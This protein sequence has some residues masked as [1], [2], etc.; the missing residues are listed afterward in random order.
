MGSLT[1]LSAADGTQVSA[2][3]AQPGQDRLDFV[4]RALAV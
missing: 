4:E 2:Y 1:R 3:V